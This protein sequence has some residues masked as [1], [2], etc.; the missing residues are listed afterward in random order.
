VTLPIGSARVTV[1]ADTDPFEREVERGVRKGTEA[2]DDDLKAAGK[3]MG[4]SL[5]ES[6]G[7]EIEKKTPGIFKRFGERFKREKIKV[8]ADVDVDVDR[9]VAERIGDE[10]AEALAGSGGRGGIIGGVGRGVA[11]AIGAG[12][13]VSGRSSL[14]ALLI[15]LI[16][17]IGF[18]IAGLLQGITALVALLYVIPS[19]LI[20]IG[21]Q[22]GVL[23]LAFK[24]LGTAIQG[25]FAAKNAK[26][27]NEAIKDLTPSAQA[28]V[29]SLLPL[30][31]LFIVL[32]RSAQENFFAQ[33]GTSITKLSD[34]LGP[35][36]LR[37]INQLAGALGVVAGTFV[38]AFTSPSF[39]KFFEQLL[40]ATVK[41]L[42][43]FGLAIAYVGQGLADLGL[44]TLP[45]FSAVGE[46]F[47]NALIMLG[48]FLTNLSKDPAFLDFLDRM[49]VT[50]PLLGD[51]LLAIGA[52]FVSFFAALDKAGGDQVLKDIADIFY[53]IA[54][55]FADPGAIKGLEGLLNLLK[56]LIGAFL[57]LG[58]VIFSV[59]A[60]LQFA[61]EEIKKGWT[62]LVDWLKARFRE[63]ADGAPGFLFTAGK[64]LIQGLID[65]A[66]S[67][68][69]NIRNAFSQ[70]AATA[71]DFWPFSPAKEGPLSGSGDPLIAGQ[72]IVQRIAAGIKMETPTLEA[73]S[74]YATNN[75]N[76]GPGSIRVGFEGI[77]P[78]PQQAE[79]TGAA[80]GRG[81]MSQLMIRDTRLQVRMAGTRG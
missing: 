79:T 80:A 32:Q 56:G 31:E 76:F 3:E 71:R 25:A 62:G 28:F 9:G 53:A 30:R 1:H 70:I 14:I 38:G 50:L 48:Q 17:A 45:F 43:G 36:L 59:L 22:A 63:F 24:G 34:I 69:P 7:D 77:V 10:I 52:A 16:G 54:A 73:A 27:L 57:V 61:A 26:E 2:A 41:W 42:D 5:S 40:P 15:P 55:F 12:F 20:A 29:R 47:N 33:F 35:I 74:S 64:N 65:G 39:T 44:A 67:K 58:I 81:I 72:K 75:I 78:T 6:F 37:N 8:K 46:G 68:L 49:R 13:N 21:V 66:L 11:D 60:F 4:D 51:A 19:A 23:F 18:L